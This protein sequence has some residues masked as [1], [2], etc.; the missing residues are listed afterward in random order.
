MTAV[1]VRQS[2]WA[3]ARFGSVMAVAWII[4]VI[5]G[6]YR[7]IE[8][9]KGSDRDTADLVSAV[10]EVENAAGEP[11]PALALLW[12]RVTSV[13]LA[14]PTLILAVVYILST[15]TSVVWSVSLW[16]SY[17]RLQGTYTTFSYIIIF[18]MILQG[19]RTREQMLKSIEKGII[20]FQNRLEITMHLLLN[21]T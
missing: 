18:F 16:G 1:S 3:L 13:P 20:R 17:Q 2:G 7:P 8:A 21:G 19:M 9:E 10:E 5:D 4:K 15:V 11:E 6:V 14:L 12:K